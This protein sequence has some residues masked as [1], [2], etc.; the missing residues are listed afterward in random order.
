[1]TVGAVPPVAIHTR[2]D[3]EL[4]D[5]LPFAEGFSVFCDG[6]P[7]HLRAMLRNA[8][9]TPGG[10]ATVATGKDGRV[11][12]YLIV[13]PPE[14]ADRFHTIVPV[15]EIAAVEVAAPYLRRGVF[16][17]MW[18][19]VYRRTV[20]G[21][22]LTAVCDPAF[23]SG[24]GSR[25]AFRRRMVAVFGSLGFSV[26]PTDHPDVHRR[27]GAFLM[28]RIGRGVP[29]SDVDTFLERLRRAGRAAS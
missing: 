20:E 3:E 7:E 22:I 17:S 12:G 5:R 15:E 8:I 19:A 6:A 25:R 23:A 27:R 21:R 1:M 9:R 2:I 18:E 29:A 26:Y 24:R 14:R 16:R 13:L 11:V 4:L 10:H 28:V